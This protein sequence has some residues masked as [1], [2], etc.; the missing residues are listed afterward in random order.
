MPIT[1]RFHSAKA[2]SSDA[3]LVN[4]SNW[5]DEHVYSLGY[6]YAGDF[7]FAPVAATGA[8]S[9]GANIID[10]GTLPLGLAVGNS[11]YISGGGG[12]AGDEAVPITAISGSTVTVTCGGTHTG[13]WDIKSAS[14]GIQEAISSSASSCVLINLGGVTIKATVN[15]PANMTVK[16]SGRASAIILDSS[17]VAFQ[18][19]DGDAGIVFKDLYFDYHTTPVNTAT[20][21]S[22]LHNFQLVLDNIEMIDIGLGIVI[23]RCF[24]PQLTNIRL[25]NNTTMFVGSIKSGTGPYGY[26][27]YTFGAQLVNIQHFTGIGV[28]SL[29][30]QRSAIVTFQR[31]INS[32]LTNFTTQGLINCADGV[33]IFSDC[34]GIHLTDGV[35]V[36]ATRAI[37]AQGGVVDGVNGN[38]SYNT[39]QG[40]QVDQY[41]DIGIW[42]GGS[43]FLNSAIDCQISG[44]QS[45]ATAAGFIS[46][47]SRSSRGCSFTH[48]KVSAISYAYGFIVQNTAYDAQI[49][50]NYFELT[51]NGADIFVQGPTNPNLQITGNQRSY[52]ATSPVFIL[53]LSTSPNVII[54]DNSGMDD[55]VGADLASGTTITPTNP[56]HTVTGTTNISTIARTDSGA[57]AFTCP[58]ILIPTDAWHLVTGGNIGN[59]LAAVAGVPVT[60]Y[61]NSA[62]NLWYAK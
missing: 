28:G 36:G 20:A 42:F 37:Y 22:C 13:A 24:D 18:C 52:L 19:V 27:N 58:L 55:I 11:L 61:W 8:L 44:A 50:D 40:T 7:D 51:S 56:M 23:D 47:S 10:L 2:D 32:S 49:K 54:K 30:L 25:T 62:T 26:G 9:G 17:I 35:I 43:S 5:N 3:T 1:H 12:T 4:P 38:P 41:Y 34:Q 29:T 21:I 33:L 14:G 46:G 31:A 45:T 6:L 16:G 57:K 53:N 15:I 48:C 59:A 39:I 60:C